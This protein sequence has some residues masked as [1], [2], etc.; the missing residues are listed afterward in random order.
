MEQAELVRQADAALSQ[1]LELTQRT[2]ADLQVRAAP[3]SWSVAQH[4]QHLS[5]AA[6]YSLKAVRLIASGEGARREGRAEVMA[7]RVLRSG[8]IPRGAQAPDPTRPSPDGDPVRTRETLDTC[9]TWLGDL[10]SADLRNGTVPHPLL[11][12]F[13]GLEWLRFV[14]VHTQ[15]HLVQIREI[16]EG[17]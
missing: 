7:R 16:L 6:E 13:D 5:L 4:L 10:E 14:D 11:G 17:S 3:D 2:E 8:V 9:R 15:H 12:L 1:A